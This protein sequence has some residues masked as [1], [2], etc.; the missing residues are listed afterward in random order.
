MLGSFQ[1]AEDAV[2]ETLMRA[3]RSRDRYED[4]GTERAWL[5]KI[6]TNRCLTMIE[7]RGRRRELPTDLTPGAA[8]LAETA[9]LEPYPDP[10]QRLLAREHM[11]LAF[12]AALQHLSGRQR[13]VLLLREVLGY[14]AGEVAELL[15]TSVAAVNSA[16]QRARRVVDE[17]RP[18]V[19]EQAE[20]AELGDERHREMARRYA[21]AWETGDVEAILAMLTDDAKYSMPPLTQWYEGR[22]DIR[23]FLVEGPLSLRWRFVP[24]HANGQMAFGTYRWDPESSLFV[25]AALD[26]IA[27]RGTSIAEVVSFLTPEVFPRFGLDPAMS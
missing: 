3:W 18:A 13:A 4:R 5:Y 10:A 14:P 11:E 22:D 9:W 24:T 26:V 8:P 21:S 27:V 17:L 12:V 16:L 19:T 20:F 25:A 15:D 7:R 6:A 23:R 1:D 2:Q